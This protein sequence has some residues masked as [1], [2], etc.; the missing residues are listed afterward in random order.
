M[1]Y[2]EAKYPPVFSEQIR[3]WDRQTDADGDELAMDIGQ[4]YNN[5]VYNKAQAERM[6]S[7][8]T[9]TLTA[10][11]WAGTGP[12]T[13]SIAVAGLLET[14]APVLLKAL[15]GTETVAQVKAY[16]KAFGLLYYGGYS[17]G[18]AEFKAYKKPA[19]DI[20]VKLGGVS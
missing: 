4:I 20:K 14:D 2:L 17:D 11:G 8:V 3:K 16:N 1:D 19:I 12:Y 18:A 5:T 13:Q 7:S 9:V 15:A 6:K 10:S